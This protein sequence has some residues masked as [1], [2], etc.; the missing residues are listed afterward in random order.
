MVTS[1]NSYCKPPYQKT[2]LLVLELFAQENPGTTHKNKLQRS[3]NLN[4]AYY[5]VVV[6]WN[7]AFYMCRSLRV[8]VKC[9]G[10]IFV[11]KWIESIGWTP[12]KIV[13]LIQIKWGF[14][15]GMLWFSFIL[16]LILLVLIEAKLIV[17]YHPIKT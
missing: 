8:M 9:T 17:T 4:L 10:A 1:Y 15:I 14:S 7:I 2:W 6:L 3:E 11:C 5:N 13:I 12:E 16:S